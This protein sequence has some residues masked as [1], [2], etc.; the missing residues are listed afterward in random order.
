MDLVVGPRCIHDVL[1]DSDDL[2]SNCMLPTLI[3]FGT[4]CRAR[5]CSLGRAQLQFRILSLAARACFPVG[6]RCASSS[7]RLANHCCP[8]RAST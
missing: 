5:P 4:P 6:Y 1:V 8:T 3:F 2:F 7:F